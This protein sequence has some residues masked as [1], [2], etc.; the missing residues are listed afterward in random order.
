MA[1]VSRIWIW[2]PV[3]ILEVEWFI[4]PT[5]PINTRSIQHVNTTSAHSCQVDEYYSTL[6][7]LSWKATKI[8]STVYAAVQSQKAVSSYFTS[9]QKLPFALQNRIVD[10]IVTQELMYS[11]QVIQVLPLVYPI[12]LLVIFVYYLKK[13]NS[14]TCDIF[15][16]PPANISNF[17]RSLDVIWS[18]FIIIEVVMFYLTS[19]LWW[20]RNKERQYN[21]VRNLHQADI[22]I[23]NLSIC[24]PL[25]KLVFT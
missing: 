24:S 23:C 16:F 9:K 17:K 20:F 7:H 11:Q 15:T 3:F 12:N 25:N 8:V 22:S 14:Y 2:L 19:G 4:L 10:F 6:S 13:M 5:I 21:L 18:N 1:A